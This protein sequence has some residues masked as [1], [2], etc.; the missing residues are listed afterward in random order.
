MPGISDVNNGQSRTLSDQEIV[1]NPDQLQQGHFV[2]RLDI[3]WLNSPFPLEGIRI[4]GNESLKWIAS[5]CSWVVV[6]LARSDEHLQKGSTNG[7]SR[8]RRL[9]SNRIHALRQSPVDSESLAAALGDYEAIGNEARRMIQA[10]QDQREMDIPLA[11]ATVKN[12]SQTLDRNLGALVWLT[13]IKNRDQYTAEHCINVAILAMG[14]AYALEWKEPEIE[15]AGLAG[16]L[17]DLGK[18]GLDR[19][20]L[21]RPGG[22][23]PDEFEHVKTHTTL[24]HEMVRGD[25]AIPES[26]ARAILEHH[27]RP[28]GLGY[29]AGLGAGKTHPVSRLISVVDAYDAI[30]SHREYSSAQSHHE[31]LG[32]LWKERDRQFDRPMVETF[33][34]FLGWVTPGTLVRLST[35][36]LAVVTRCQIGQRLYP[37]VRLLDNAPGGLKAGQILDL[38]AIRES[39]DQPAVRITDILP[40]NTE[41]L[42]LKRLSRQ[43]AEMG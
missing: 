28:D 6:D 4:D 20:I 10:L 1:V 29:P 17:H 2:S 39:G 38:T 14:M 7:Q 36:A 11:E 31:A 30:T 24:G 26:V 33:I 37:E 18:I 16:L 3:P 40:D 32:I 22:L 21:N 5:H 25:P 34:Q 23:T 12:L 19:E 35:G 9:A 27:E 43:I 8:T 15:Q 41:G 42:D 13:R